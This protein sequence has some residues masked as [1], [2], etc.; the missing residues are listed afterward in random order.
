M[1]TTIKHVTLKS[2]GKNKDIDPSK[3]LVTHP[4]TQEEYNN[5]NQTGEWTGGYVEAMGYV[6]PPMMDGMDDGSGSSDI[7]DDDYLTKP[8]VGIPISGGSKTAEGKIIASINSQSSFK[9]L[10]DFV[11]SWTDGR[12]GVQ[13]GGSLSVINNTDVKTTGV[14]ILTDQNINLNINATSATVANLDWNKKSRNHYEISYSLKYSW[15]FQEKSHLSNINGQIYYDGIT[16]LTYLGKPLTL[17][18]GS[19]QIYLSLEDDAFVIE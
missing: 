1:A 8:Y 19:G 15:D 17:M 14:T 9:I 2:L 6:A 3:G 13:H 4:F 16:L 18:M 7:E 11:I 12:T 10:F 5:L